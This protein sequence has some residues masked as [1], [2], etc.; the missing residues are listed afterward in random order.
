MKKPYDKIQYLL[1]SLPR[2]IQVGFALYCA[3]DAFEYVREEDK[4]VI[5]TCLDT[6]QRWLQG[7]ASDKEVRD[8]AVNAAHAA[9]AA[10]YAAAADAAY[11]ADAAADAAA[12]AADAVNAADAAYAAYAAY[13][14]VNAANT[15]DE[16]MEKYLYKLEE[17]ISMLSPVE[18]ILWNLK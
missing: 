18:K 11:A 12:C 6:T 14:A 4:S 2:Y 3:E 10:D 15:H 13:A 17:M 7:K 8:A 9:D 16:K 1:P 5:R